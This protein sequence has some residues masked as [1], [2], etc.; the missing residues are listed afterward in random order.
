[1]LF[2]IVITISYITDMSIGF[3][4]HNDDFLYMLELTEYE[5][6]DSEISDSEVYL[7]ST[8]SLPLY[9][10][11][12]PANSLNQWGDVILYFLLPIVGVVTVADF[13]SGAVKNLL[14]SGINRTKYFLS[15][16][17]LSF[18][19]V[20]TMFLSYTV[21]PTIAV[22]IDNGFG[23]GFASGTLVSL[24]GRS[25]LVLAAT[26]FAIMLAFVTKKAAGMIGGYLAALLGTTT[27]LLILAGINGRFWPW[28]E[29]EFISSFNRF[30]VTY[31]TTLGIGFNLS[32]T[33]TTRIVMMGFV[34]LAFSVSIGF[35]AFRKAEIK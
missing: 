24:A 11:N 19:I 1:M 6:I 21:L 10:G 22:T 15:K 16:L 7:Y 2:N 9:G 13:S 3:N 17:F 31:E 29:Y 28:L 34:I 8:N 35:M 20:M 5:I 23:D 25:L 26:S 12:M 27:V 18:A 14:A 33:D 4:G 30:A 32:T